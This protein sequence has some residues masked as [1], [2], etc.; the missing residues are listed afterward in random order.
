MGICLNMIVKNEALNLARLF[1]SLRSF[2]S[3]YVISDTGST[4]NTVEVISQLGNQYNIEGLVHEDKWVDFATNRNHA[5]DHARRALISGKH[6]CSWLLIIDAD[7]EFIVQDKQFI[8]KLLPET[9]YRIYKNINGLCFKHLAL[10]NVHQEEWRWKGAIHNYLAGR[11]SD[12]RVLYLPGVYIKCHEFEGA[13]SRP[14]KSRTEKSEA[15]IQILKK[16]LR[17]KSLSN[18]NLHRF[19]QLGMEYCT[20]SQHE[21]AIEMFQAIANYK[22]SGAEITYSSCI[23]L[24]M[25]FLEEFKDFSQSEQYCFQAIRINDNRKEAFYYLARIRLAQ[26][27]L[28]AAAEI[29]EKAD[30]IPPHSNDLYFFDK[31]ISDW[32]IRFQLLTIF[33]RMNQH[34][35]AKDLIG[36]LELTDHL[37]RECKAIVSGFKYKYNLA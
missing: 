24:A 33:V 3:Y 23:F 21:K 18:Q 25:I 8:S 30:Q 15:D 27:D 35:R 29:L 32:K 14:F 20:T 36:K 19:F 17:D 22:V 7:E 34:G 16:E 2:I 1:S 13:K 31:N 12:C 4:D 5:L 9:S 6:R 11:S 37:S 26:G 28:P 10:L